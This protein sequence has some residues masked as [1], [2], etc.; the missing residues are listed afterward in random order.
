MRDERLCSPGMERTE[1]MVGGANR[2]RSGR[3]SRHRPDGESRL[4]PEYRMLWKGT[5]LISFANFPTIN[6]V[7]SNAAELRLV[8]RHVVGFP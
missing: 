2:I 4:V 1:L 3:V 8:S 6:S 7:L 5:A